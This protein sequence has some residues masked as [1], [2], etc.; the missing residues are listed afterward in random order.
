MPKRTTGNKDIFCSFCGRFKDEVGKIIAGPNGIYICDDC[1]DLC[2]R[3]ILEDIMNDEDVAEEIA[4]KTEL[5]EN[6]E[7]PTP[8]QI[9]KILDEYVIG[10]DMAKK[11]LSVS[12]YN[13][14]KRIR[15]LDKI[16]EVEIN[17]SNI[18]T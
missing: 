11:V 6:T 14:Y 18:F 10:Q 12:V 15:N 5:I 7:L 3:V 2:N 13:H 9:N 8:E 17:K 1:V 4:K 16:D